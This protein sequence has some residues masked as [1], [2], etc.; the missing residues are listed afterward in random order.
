MSFEKAQKLAEEIARRAEQSGKISIFSIAN[1]ANRNNAPLLFPAI[2]ETATTIA[3][4]VLVTSFEQIAEMAKR[5]DGIVKIILLDAEIKVA[6]LKGAQNEIEKLFQKSRVYTYK[7]NDM[8]VE[9]IDH[10]L[11]QTAAPL[12]KKRIGVIGAGNIGSKIALRLIERGAAVTLTKPDAV[13]L[14]K[15][16]EGLNEI[17]PAFIETKIC[18]TVDNKA[19]SQNADILIGCTAGEGVIDKE[20]VLQMNAG[21]IILDV[22]NGTVFPEAIEVARSR[23]IQLFCLFVKPAYDGTIQ[24]L[25]ETKKLIKKMGHRSLGDFCMISGGVMGKLGDIIVDDV[26]APTRILAIA[27]GSGDV[28]ADSD[29]PRFLA[30]VKKVQDL[31]KETL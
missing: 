11:S 2:R 15:I 25:F 16:V 12:S 3:G 5:I 23:E 4:N 6:G 31:M 24:T 21:G 14:Q 1:T 17:K 28:L 27:N 20:M 26:S 8:T 13:S 29:D 9:A 10:F 7:P 18:G 22:G 19:A 30:H